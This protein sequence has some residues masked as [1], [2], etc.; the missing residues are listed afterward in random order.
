LTLSRLVVTAFLLAATSAHAQ[1]P[2]CAPVGAEERVQPFCA[3]LSLYAAVRFLS[4]FT[5]DHH[6][7]PAPPAIQRSA[8][9][10]TRF[11]IGK[12]LADNP[13]LETF[14]RGL[15]PLRFIQLDRSTGT[16]VSDFGK[17]ERRFQGSLKGVEGE[18]ALTVR[19]PASLQGGY[20]RAPD[21]LQIAFWQNQRF[22]VR[23]DYGNGRAFDAEVECIALSPDGLL[24]RFASPGAAP[25]L[26]QFRE[27]E[28]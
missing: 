5:V 14:L 20:W 11:V 2:V 21:V 28:Q 9:D 24:A 23:M 15:E 16:L 3:P 26:L 12:Q 19:M 8:L 27:C 10:T 22:A 7:K 25:L 18:P 4:E 1:R 17:N 13:A 6:F